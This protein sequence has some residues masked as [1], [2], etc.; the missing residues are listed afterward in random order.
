MT[1]Y[2]EKRD[3]QRM[4]LDSTLEYQMEN[5]SNTY[6]GTVKNLS[7]KGVLFSTTE[8]VPLDKNVI[9]KLTPVNNITPPMSADVKITR[10]DKVSDNEFQVAGSILQI[11]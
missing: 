9:I 5:D 1:E 7:A 10:C 4:T 2:S 8:E 6:Q 3:F 11:K